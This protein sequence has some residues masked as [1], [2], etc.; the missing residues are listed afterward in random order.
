MPQERDDS[1]GL[2]PESSKKERPAPLLPYEPADPVSCR[3]R[4]GLIGCGGISIQHL[5]AYR[6]AGYEV[7]MLCDRTESKADELRRKFYPRARTSTDFRDVLKRDDIDVV[8]LAA[9]PGD[10]AAMYGPAIEAG[11]HI[12]SQK[13]FVT[14]L[15]FGLRVAETAHRRGVLLAVNQNGR[16]APHWS[17]IRAA[18]S[19]G[20]LGDVTSVR[21]AVNWDHNWVAGS[22][23]ETMHSLILYDFGIHWFDIVSCF[24]GT[25]RPLRVH[26][27]AARAP[28]QR[29]RPPL[30][31]Q[32]IVEYDDAQA[33]LVFDANTLFGE[34]DS[35]F[36]AGT[37]GTAES[38]GPS[39][40]R[41]E[42][43]FSTAEGRSRP[44][45]RG[46]WF[47]DGFHGTMGELLRAIEEKRE[48]TNNALDNIRSLE[49]C[50][51]A[52]ASAASHE[53]VT[54]GTVR[55]LQD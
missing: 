19:Q 13:P 36:V 16:W 28:S 30:L 46:A 54:P 48:P 5:R 45:L 33:A 23:F 37:R 4:I 41:Q 31:S 3:P 49:L 52:V 34:Q 9:Q 27:S 17:W 42:V 50:F 44:S 15:D 11:K 20:L 2:A 43:T 35:T 14:D 38:T 40:N 32:A 47:P 26:A 55:K 10:R 39:L 12:L 8:D 1:Y 51:A 29:V 7:V 6:D 24:M 18:I 25:R 53:P 21:T 22:V